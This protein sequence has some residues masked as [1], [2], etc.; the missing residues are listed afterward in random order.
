[1]RVFGPLWGVRVVGGWGLVLAGANCVVLQV[2]GLWKALGGGEVEMLRCL[3]MT[4]E[5]G[6]LVLMRWRLEI[7][8]ERGVL[9][10]A[11]STSSLGLSPWFLVC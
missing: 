4:L 10:I 11:G 3:G 1:M 6:W 5:Y 9:L 7:G 2:G 8:V